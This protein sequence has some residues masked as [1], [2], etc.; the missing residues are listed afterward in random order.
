MIARSKRSRS[1]ASIVRDRSGVEIDP[2]RVTGPIA[3]RFHLGLARAAA[4]PAD[5]PPL[6]IGSRRRLPELPS[7]ERY[8]LDLWVDPARK[9]FRGEVEIRLEI[10]AGTRSI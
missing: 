3:S 6:Q 1:S 4:L 8:E 10:E 7:P 9:A 2:A 5:R